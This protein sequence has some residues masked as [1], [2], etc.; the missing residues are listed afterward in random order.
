MFDQKVVDEM[1]IWENDMAPRLPGTELFKVFFCFDPN[2]FLE[3]KI[4][5]P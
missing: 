1:E 4:F 5:G 3:N 2:F